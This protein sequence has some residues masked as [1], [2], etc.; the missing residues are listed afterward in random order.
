M[1]NLVMTGAAGLFLALGAAGA[2]AA[3]PNVPTFS[4]YT[5][6]DIPGSVPETERT[7]NPAWAYTRDTGM[8]EG[9]SAY[10]EPGAYHRHVH[11]GWAS[12]AKTGYDNTREDPAYPNG[13]GAGGP[14]Y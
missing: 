3:N 12:D 2:Q 14:Q 7:S 11:Q 1:R 9:R 8:D 13:Y 10:V 4:P 5:L 6:M